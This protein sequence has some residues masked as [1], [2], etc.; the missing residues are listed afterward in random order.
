LLPLLQFQ[1]VLWHARFVGVMNIIIYEWEEIS[2][3]GLEAAI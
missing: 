3:C 2:H 1:L